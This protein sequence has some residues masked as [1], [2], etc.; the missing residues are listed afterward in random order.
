MTWT[1]I[2]SNTENRIRYGANTH[3]G[4]NLAPYTTNIGNAIDQAVSLGFDAIRD[5]VPWNAFEVSE[6]VYTFNPSGDTYSQKMFT[7][8]SYIQ[9]NDLDIHVTLGALYGNALYGVPSGGLAA[10]SDHFCD[11][12]EYAAQQ[13]LAAGYDP[14]ML[15]MELWNEPNTTTQTVYWND[16]A[17]ATDLATVMKDFYTRIKA[18]DPGILVQGVATADGWWYEHNTNWMDNFW[19]NAGWAGA[20]DAWSDHLYNSAAALIYRVGESQSWLAAEKPDWGGGFYKDFL[21]AA[22]LTDG[23]SYMPLVINEFGY[24]T[25]ADTDAV[26]KKILPRAFAVYSTISRMR[27][28]T[29]Y[30]LLDS[31]A[32]GTYGLCTSVG[33]VKDQGTSVAAILAHL[34]R[35]SQRHYFRTDVYTTGHHAVL[36]V[37]PDGQRLA[38]WTLAGDTSVDIAVNATL[39]GT[40]SIQTIGSTTATQS[41]TAGANTVTLTLTDTAKVIYANVAIEFTEFV[42]DAV[43]D[44]AIPPQGHAYTA[45][46][47]SNF[48]SIESRIS[49]LERADNMVAPIMP[50]AGFYEPGQ[51]VRCTDTNEYGATNSKYCILGWLRLTDGTAH[52]LD[53]DWREMRALTGN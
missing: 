32:G 31:A 43:I 25:A 21:P 42:I 10:W 1:L 12:F 22:A 28:V 20:M 48:S 6:G 13:Y 15:T 27:E 38:V 29:S 19:G 45:P 5:N 16:D 52:V 33:N 7:A 49:E 51:F 3:F 34:K 35:A 44:T 2:Q 47:R 36:L 23:K 46:V 17:E 53:V 11:A 4:L 41:I 40:L 30:E 26:I 24:A 18:V 37:C 14:A 50:S 8:L 39:G 9:S